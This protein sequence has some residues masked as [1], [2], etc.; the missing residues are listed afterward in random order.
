MIPDY[1]SYMYHATPLGDMFVAARAGVLTWCVWRAT[2]R[3]AAWMSGDIVREPDCAVLRQ[4]AE[5]LD[6]YFAGCEHEVDRPALEQPRTAFR[7]E[8][9]NAMDR[10]GRGQ[11]IS[12]GGLAAA[13][14]VPDGARAVAGAV[15][16]NRLLLMRPCHRV[17]G[18]DGKL[19]GY[20]SGLDI[21]A[22]LL[23]M[24]SRG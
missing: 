14:G 21:M 7:R 19:H 23:E 22:A 3:Y 18:A 16:A 12:Y 9:Y 10:I 1:D 8:V 17:V 20:A 6:A 2:P 13:V 5:W 4:A 11:T 15:A 24:E